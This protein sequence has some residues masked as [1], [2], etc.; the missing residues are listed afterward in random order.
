MF[1]L[2][3][4]EKLGN[5]HKNL[6]D[7]IINSIDKLNTDKEIYELITSYIIKNNL[8]KA[9]PIGISINNIV[10]HDSYHESNIKKL[11]KGDYI[12]IDIGLI[13]NGNIIDSARTFVYKEQ[14]TKPITDCEF[15]VGEIEKYI[16]KQI[17]L[18]GYVEIQRISTLTNAL[19]VSKGYN[20]VGLLGGHT[21]ELG[22]VHGKHLILNQPLSL[23]PQSASN[24]IDS[25]A[26]IYN[27]DMFAI[28]VYIPEMKSNGQLIQN[29]NIPITHYQLNSIDLLDDK[30]KLS[31][32]EL[33]LYNKIENE[34]NG[35]VYEYFIHKKYD[36]K[37]INSLVSK[38]AIIKHYALDYKC[39]PMI[40]YVQYEDCFLIKD[41]KLINLSKK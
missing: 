15:I 39:N 14:V 10:A 5:H 37:I 23:L 32:K 6:M 33:D 9:F 19:I 3:I 16:R 29:I 20:S 26:K 12:K 17:E 35:L 24:L 27:N 38:N 7:I 21:I 13:E 11:K 22:K 1:D 40:K 41:N 30:I 36:E 25:S 2:E 8:R 31:D 28:E 34:T 4:L 18:N